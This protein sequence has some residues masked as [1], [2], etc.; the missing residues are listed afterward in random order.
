MGCEACNESQ[1]KNKW[2]SIMEGWGNYLFPNQEV[3]K[4]AKT[5]ALICSACKF[6]MLGMCTDCTGI[7][8][9]ISTKT[10]SMQ[11]KC[12]KWKQ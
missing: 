6:N 12:E 4:I 7:P 1:G 11:E 9:P 5:R 8:C 3:E 2:Q 10:R